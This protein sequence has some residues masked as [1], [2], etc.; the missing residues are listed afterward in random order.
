MTLKEALEI[1]DKKF[2]PNYKLIYGYCWIA[3]PSSRVVIREKLG[4]SK[5]VV[6]QAF[7]YFKQNNM[8]LP[9]A[10][11]ITRI[12]IDPRVK[13][14]CLKARK[15]SIKKEDMLEE[16]FEHIDTFTKDDF[17]YLI[18]NGFFTDVKV[19]AQEQ[20]ENLT[21]FVGVN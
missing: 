5:E 18:T 8:P 17:N 11:I 4:L 6:Q 20:F 16:L 13:M 3:K 1:K 15:K 12:E 2:R 7:T 10:L 21:D 14:L 9:E 19:W